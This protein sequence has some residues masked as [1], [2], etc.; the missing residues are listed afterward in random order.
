MIL[1]TVKEP[2]RR[3]RHSWNKSQSESFGPIR[4]IGLAYSIGFP[5][6]VVGVLLLAIASS[7]SGAFLWILGGGLF[8]A[9]ILAAGSG[10]IT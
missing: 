1:G 4:Q 2:P 9:G 5:L 7:E 3:R 6:M 8:A 10:R